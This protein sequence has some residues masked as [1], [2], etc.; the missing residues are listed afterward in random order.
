MFV[1]DYPI[2]SAI[3]TSTIIMAITAASATTGYLARGNVDVT[4]GL[5]VAA[6]TVIG[7][8]SGARFANIVSERALSKIV[9]GIFMVL[10]VVM[11]VL[12]FI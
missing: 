9:G 7:G 4:A 1:L 5:I 12:R 2:H 10:G 8:L 11:T 3:G 6:G